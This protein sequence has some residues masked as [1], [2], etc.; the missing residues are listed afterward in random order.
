M[1]AITARS[2]KVFSF[3]VRRD[4]EVGEPRADKVVLPSALACESLIR[5]VEHGDVFYATTSRHKGVNCYKHQSEMDNHGGG[6][7]K[8]AETKGERA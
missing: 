7:I 1:V 8:T 6:P 2:L 3:Q 4:V 5:L